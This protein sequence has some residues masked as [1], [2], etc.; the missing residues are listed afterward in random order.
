MF[1]NLGEVG[2]AYARQGSHPLLVS[3]AALKEDLRP[4][5]LPFTTHEDNCNLSNFF[6]YG[7]IL[8]VQ[9]SYD[10]KKSVYGESKSGFYNMHDVRQLAGP[11]ANGGYFL[12]NKW[13]LWP[14]GDKEAFEK[15]IR[16][17]QVVSLPLYLRVINGVS[18]GAWVLY[19]AGI[20]AVIFWMLQN[21][22]KRA[23][24]SIRADLND[25]PSNKIH[26]L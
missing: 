3:S 11:A 15:F 23:K 4:V 9:L 17:K 21:G 5:S 12:K 13:P 6:G 22:Q 25:K 10:P 2:Y 24:N 26:G 7:T 14:K 20:A 16:Y 8:P 19:F 1:L 18:F